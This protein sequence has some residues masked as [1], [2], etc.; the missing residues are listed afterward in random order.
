MVAS[1]GVVVGVGIEAGVDVSLDCNAIALPLTSARG[2]VITM[3][4]FVLL[5]IAVGVAGNATIATTTR[6]NATKTITNPEIEVFILF[7]N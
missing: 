5:F 7:F 6:Q 4:L 2:A 1:I 3:A